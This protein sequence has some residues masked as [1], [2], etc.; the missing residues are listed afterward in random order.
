MNP[1]EITVSNLENVWFNQK[2][3]IESTDSKLSPNLAGC[4]A[5]ARILNCV[6]DAI[7]AMIDRT[8]KYVDAGFAFT[9]ADDAFYRKKLELRREIWLPLVRI[10]GYRPDFEIDEHPL[11]KKGLV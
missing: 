10:S 1:L 11:A 2:L 5:A 8:E 3:D 6:M 4:I 9:D 7:A